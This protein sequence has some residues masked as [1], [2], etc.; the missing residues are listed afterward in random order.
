MPIIGHGHGH[1]Q[2]RKPHGMGL[3]FLLHCI[4]S[5]NYICKGDTQETNVTELKLM[6]LMM[7]M[8]MAMILTNSF[9]LTSG[10]LPPTSLAA[11]SS[12]LDARLSPPFSPVQSRDH[13]LCAHHLD[14]HRGV[15]RMD[16]YPIF[17]TCQLRKKNK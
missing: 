17:A 14:N 16:I 13:N 6:M 3:V 1:G 8:M 11:R 9:S 7:V 10:V 2:I 15:S 4:G 5:D 12:W